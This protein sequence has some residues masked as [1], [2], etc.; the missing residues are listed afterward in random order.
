[1]NL[2]LPTTKHVLMEW[3]ARTRAELEATIAAVPIDRREETLPSGLSV[4]DQLAHVTFWERS[5]LER[6]DTSAFGQ[7]NAALSCV[8]DA[9]VDTIN[10]QVHAQHYSQSWDVLH[11]DFEDVHGRVVEAITRLSDTDIFD[12]A[13]APALIG[14]DAYTILERIYA[15]TIEHF[16]EHTAEI[17]SWLH[18][19]EDAATRA[20]ASLCPIVRPEES[21]TGVQGL[22]YF[23][24][25]SAQNVGA[26]ALCMHLLK[27]PPGVRA[28]AH[29]HDSHETVIYLI[30]GK[31]AMFYGPQLEHHLEMNAGDFLYI[32]AGV[33]HLPYNP[34]PEAAVAVLSRT[35]PN[36]QESV[37][38]LP[39]LDTRLSIED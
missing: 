7:D 3:I 6:L 36:E 16:V 32:P 29:L 18:G 15:E 10:A 19:A 38:L 12:S 9:D 14:V 22:T 25:V 20:G 1:M 24:G 21:Y 2:P 26:R 11:F 4:K 30:S 37:R 5:L 17:R 28:R 33:P 35:D 8:A 23:A 39:E 27:M 13:H 31:A 34:F